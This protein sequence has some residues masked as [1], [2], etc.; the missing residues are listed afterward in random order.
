MANRIENRRS[1]Y[2]K[3]GY[4]KNT[5]YVDGSAVRD[6]D[7]V[8]ELEQEP[9]KEISNR[10]R[11]NREKAGH[12][13]FGYVL[14]LAAAMIISSY[15]LI[16]LIQLRAELTSTV[17]NISSLESELNS[18]KM[19]NDEEYNRIEAGIDLDEIKRIATQEMGMVYAREGQVYTYSGE[20]YDYVSQSSSLHE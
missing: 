7:V 5:A 2:R 10:T 17:K 18:L 3:P 14:F 6:F 11:K 19:A 8:R 12:M 15:V 16:N 13:T 9:L 1:H 4:L 20:G